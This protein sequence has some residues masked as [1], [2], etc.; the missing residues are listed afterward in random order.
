MKSVIHFGYATRFQQRSTREAAQIGAT[1]ISSPAFFLL[2]A[3]LAWQPAY[4]DPLYKWVDSSG[5]VIYSSLP[6]PAGTRVEK[7][8]EAPQP[9][10]EEIRQ[11]EERTKRIEEQASEMEAQRLEQEAKEAEEARLR[12]LQ[13]PPEP[14]VIEKPVYMPQPFYYPPVMKSPRARHDDKPPLRR[15]RKEPGKTTH[16]APF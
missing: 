15:P 10:A 4:A 6:P 14:I 16:D 13:S 7:V 12:A 1:M 8:Q 5:Q 11:T 2:L 9:S 3:G